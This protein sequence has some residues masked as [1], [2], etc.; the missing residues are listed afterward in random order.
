[1]VCW[2][3]K[4]LRASAFAGAVS[5]VFVADAVTTV[6]SGMAV[7]LF[8]LAIVLC[9]SRNLWAFLVMVKVAKFGDVIWHGHEPVFQADL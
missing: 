9:T 8:F 5:I 6:R 3:K 2:Q 4:V 1:M 7:F